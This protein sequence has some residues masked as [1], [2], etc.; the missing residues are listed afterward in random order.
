M[1]SICSRRCCGPVAPGRGGGGRLKIRPL[2]VGPNVGSAAVVR[3]LDRLDA[4]PDQVK[5]RVVGSDRRGT[6]ATKAPAPATGRFACCAGRLLCVFRRRLADFGSSAEGPRPWA[7]IGHD[8]LEQSGLSPDSP[9]PAPASG[10]RGRPTCSRRES[11]SV[12]FSAASRHTSLRRSPDLDSR[13]AGEPR[14]DS[15]G[16]PGE[17]TRRIKTT[18]R[19]GSS[20]ASTGA[21]AADAG[22]RSQGTR[23]SVAGTS[24]MSSSRSALTMRGC[25]DGS[26]SDSPTRL[27]G[28]LNQDQ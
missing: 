2:I 13:F 28:R 26:A 10:A 4:P 7:I 22:E 1:T 12:P 21:A 9:C 14:V 23:S 11:V 20:A 19:T 17:I 27:G 3:R 5:D 15:L 18:A 6:T 8:D 24:R 25:T 16:Q